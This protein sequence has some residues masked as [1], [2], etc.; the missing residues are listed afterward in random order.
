V[1]EA[2]AA[3]DE[4]RNELRVRVIDAYSVK[5]IDHGGDRRR[6]PRDGWAPLRRRGPLG[7]GRPRRRRARGA[8]PKAASRTSSAPTRTWPCERC[9][10]PGK[11]SELLDAAGI[12]A[13]H[14]VR[15]VRTLAGGSAVARRA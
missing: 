7:R 11:P 13:S 5:P 9:R 10:R 15:A 4:L 1:H 12:S 3:A 6:A 14:I 2:I 8:W